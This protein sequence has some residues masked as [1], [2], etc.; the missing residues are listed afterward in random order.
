MAEI[1]RA[2]YRLLLAAVVGPRRVPWGQP[3]SKTLQPPAFTLAGG[4]RQLMYRNNGDEPVFI[5]VALKTGFAGQPTFF[6]ST[7]NPSADNSELVNLAVAPNQ[8]DTVVLPGEYLYALNI[9]LFL[10]Q[11]VI[12]EVTMPRGR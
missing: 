7:K 11:V 1:T 5:R 8:Y 2:E 4:G 3:T 9:G 10:E 6:S 12:F